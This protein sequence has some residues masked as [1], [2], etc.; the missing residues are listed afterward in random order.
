MTEQQPYQQPYQ[1][2]S[3]QQIEEQW[4]RAMYDQI[5]K[6]T[7][8]LQSIDSW[9]AWCVVLLFLSLIF[10]LFVFLSGKF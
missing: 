4:Q 3:S 9:V 8:M 2:P 10:G 7:V 5:T 6:Q 1:Q